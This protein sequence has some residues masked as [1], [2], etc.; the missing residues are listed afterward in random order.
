MEGVKMMQ[1]VFEGVILGFE[2]NPSVRVLHMCVSG[3]HQSCTDFWSQPHLVITLRESHTL[4]QSKQVFNPY[5]V[6]SKNRY[7]RAKT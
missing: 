3:L 7:T 6:Y 2:S 1:H 4:T 5:S